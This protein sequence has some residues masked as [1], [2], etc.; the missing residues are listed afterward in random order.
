[1]FG[2][3]ENKVKKESD[4]LFLKAEIAFQLKEV[5]QCI[6]SYIRERA[7]EDEWIQEF[8]PKGNAY[9]DLM[10]LAVEKL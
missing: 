2:D 10:N 7:Y 1:M 3:N 6:D 5:V 8:A 9:T 4:E